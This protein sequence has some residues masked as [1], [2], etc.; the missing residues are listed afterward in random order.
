MHFPGKIGS[1]LKFHQN[2]R[3]DSL[4]NLNMACY[5]WFC[6]QSIVTMKLIVL[7]ILLTGMTFSFIL[8]T[9][10]DAVPAVEL[11]NIAYGS[12]SQQ[13]MDVYLPANRSESTR[14][15]VVIHGGAWV[16]GDKMEMQHM[17]DSLKL[18]FPDYAFVN[19]NYR[20]AANGITNVFPAQEND[21]KAAIDFYLGKS[22]EY[23][24][25]KDLVL[26]GV[27]AGG[28]L[29]LLHGYKNDPDK[30]VKAIIDGFG[31][32]DLVTTNGG[33]LRSALSYITGTTYKANPALYQ[34][35]SP[36]FYITP[37]SPPTLAMHGG[38]DGLVAPSQTES[39]ITK[40]KENG[41]ICEQ[42]IYPR[43]GHGWGV[44]ALT[45][46]F[47]KIEVF[48]RETVKETNGKSG[49]ANL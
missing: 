18:R 38:M 5:C 3:P 35:S 39:L 48:I 28:H 37:K 14:T 32:T 27:S 26:F 8:S 24:V 17:I 43:E 41:V 6:I 33:S 42:V 13:Q 25:S 40:L 2:E 20:L 29:A 7:L 34:E 12:S 45:D 46:S 1:F 47:N 44:P 31:P 10:R 9:G 4:E 49:P 21:V 36:L 11:T 16:R 15:F 19:L 22:S 23:N 30:H